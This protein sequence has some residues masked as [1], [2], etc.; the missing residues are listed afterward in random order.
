MNS[1]YL[2]AISIKR[3]HTT[4]SRHSFFQSNFIL[5]ITGNRWKNIFLFFKDSYVGLS[6]ASKNASKQVIKMF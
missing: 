6:F 2:F 1:F 3:N 4:W 5:Y